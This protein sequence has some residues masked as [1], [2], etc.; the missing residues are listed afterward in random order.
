M[1]VNGTALLPAG[2]IL[3]GFN[4]VQDFAADKP[5]KQMNTSKK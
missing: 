5:K 4:A 1:N 3:E 2:L